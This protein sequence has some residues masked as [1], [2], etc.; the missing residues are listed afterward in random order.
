MASARNMVRVTAKFQIPRR[1]SRSLGDKAECNEL[2]GPVAIIVAAR[3]FGKS[4]G[5]LLTNVLR[6][7][8]IA[9]PNPRP[10]ATNEAAQKTVVDV[11]VNR[12][13]KATPQIP[14]RSPTTM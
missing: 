8:C 6:G 5:I 14:I 2:V 10:L 4:C 1:I 7:S 11:G 9:I 13:S 3:P 12:V